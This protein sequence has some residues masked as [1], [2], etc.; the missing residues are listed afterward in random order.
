MKTL[1]EN[2]QILKNSTDAIKQA[3]V[4]KGGVINGDIS[5]WASAISGI[6]GGEAGTVV[7]IK[8]KL[9]GATIG[10]LNKLYDLEEVIYEYECEYASE[11]LLGNNVICFNCISFLNNEDGIK[12]QTSGNTIDLKVS[13]DGNIDPYLYIHHNLSYDT[14]HKVQ[15][16]LYRPYG[17]YIGGYGDDNIKVYFIAFDSSG[18]YDIDIFNVQYSYATCFLKDTQISL[19]DGLTKPVQEITYNDELLV[20]NFDER[21]F[22][23]AKP[24]WIKKEEKTNY[25]YKVSLENG[26]TINLVGSNGKCHRLF[27][28]TDQLFESATDLIGK[29]VYTLNGLS[30][31]VSVD[32]IEEICEYYNI[33]TEYHINLFANGIL[34]SCRYNNLY[35]IK[36]MMFDKT[37]VALEPKYKIHERFKQYPEISTEYIRG[38]RLDEIATPNFEEI[39]TYIS[40]LD[41]LKKNV[42]DFEENKNIITN[43]TTTNVGWV[44]PDGNVYGY[45][46]YMPGQKIHN[47]LANIICDKLGYEK[48]NKNC[49]KILEDLGWVK[50]T[51]SYVSYYN[52]NKELTDVQEREILKFI[53]NNKMVKDRG[54]I[55]LGSII[56]KETPINN[57]KIT[58]KKEL[59]SKINLYYVNKKN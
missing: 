21:K 41:R 29:E 44:D 8:N 37:D 38:M 57:V 51:N 20:W 43:I 13:G 48:N 3:I 26:T 55:K 25:Y 9:N 40:N 33:I 28:Y 58:P 56:S 4:D 42:N 1:A 16:S 36:N 7:K 50:Y 54:S 59:S 47:I 49:F 22:D 17:D 32:K 6:S 35:P 53:N 19:S 39:K 24:L 15:I 52:E 14:N 5:N 45:K 31:V 12:L 18:N 11:D 27:N 2:L 10:E 34:T 23:K 46:L 30:K